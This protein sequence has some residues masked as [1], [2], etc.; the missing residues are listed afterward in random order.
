MAKT[1]VIYGING[2]VVS[3]AGDPGFQMNEMVYVGKENLVGE[4][5]GLT[6]EKTTIQVYEETSGLNIGYFTLSLNVNKEVT[7]SKDLRSPSVSL[8]DINLRI[9]RQ[10]KK[11][12][13]TELVLQRYHS[14]FRVKNPLAEEKCLQRL[15]K[16]LEKNPCINRQDYALL[17]GKTKTQALQDINAFIEK[18]ILKKYGAGRSVVYIKVG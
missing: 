4:V 3:L 2:P 6:S 10:F 15:N 11:D 7:D 13:E 14:P 12:I 1:G 16:F 17:V 9:N 18:G 5:I 8:K